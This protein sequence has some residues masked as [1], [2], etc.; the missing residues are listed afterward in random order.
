MSEAAL[1]T[2]LRKKMVPRYWS[3][4]TRHED[5]MQTGIADLSFIVRRQVKPGHSGHHGWME[6]KYR[7]EAPK[8]A[9]T[10]CKLDHYT[11]DQRNWLLKKGENA[12]YTFLLLQLGRDYL[13]FDW[14]GAQD[15]G[16]ITTAELYDTA[17]WTSKGK[18]DARGLWHAIIWHGPL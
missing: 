6:L 12:G 14:Q 18:L 9:S 13:L 15:V 17:T 1:W 4:A 8:R 10:I 7:A 5:V 2:N 3:E 11:Q 16:R